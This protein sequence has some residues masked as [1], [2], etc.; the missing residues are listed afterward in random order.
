MTDIKVV[1]YTEKID[2]GVVKLLEDLLT[3]AKEGTLRA[4][5]IAGITWQRKA[6]LAVSETVYDEHAA[7]IV[8]SLVRLQNHI[9]SQNL[10]KMEIHDYS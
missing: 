5:A 10:A 8:G 1:A 7:E 2:P 9:C 6:Y 3:E 4:V